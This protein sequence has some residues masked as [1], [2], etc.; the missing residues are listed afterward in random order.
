MVIAIIGLLVAIGL[1]VGQA[2]FS[3]GERQR[4]LGML[5]GLD[6]A[7]EELQIQTG[8]IVDHRDISGFAT[9]TGF[10]LATGERINVDGEID[11]TSDDNTIG[12]FVRACWQS[13][14]ARQMLLSALPDQDLN[15]RVTNGETVDG[16]ALPT[17]DPEFVGI[18]DVEL[19]D[20]WGFR[21]RYARGVS[22]EDNFQDDDYLPAHPRPFFASP[23]PDGKWGSA[24]PSANDQE[25][26]DAEDNLYSFEAD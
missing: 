14:E 5:S 17:F 3:Q 6:A 12:L 22:Y 15:L 24:N 19:L 9:A 7:M 10:D 13:R 20:S 21:L 11:D 26:A 16:L 25:Q 2:V 23:G 4:T 1:P 18:D 8:R